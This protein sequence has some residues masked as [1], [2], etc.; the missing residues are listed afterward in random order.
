M[1]PFSRSF[2]CNCGCSTKGKHRA[3]VGWRLARCSWGRGLA[4]EGALAIVRYGFEKL[5]LERVIS[6][7]VPENVA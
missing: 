5:G 1:E 3:E 4:T 2:P 7:T 6:L